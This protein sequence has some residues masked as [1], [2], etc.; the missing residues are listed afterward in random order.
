MTVETSITERSEG[1]A[2]IFCPSKRVPRLGARP[3]PL[4]VL[5]AAQAFVAARVAD[6]GASAVLRG[7]TGAAF[8]TDAGNAILDCRFGPIA[9]PAA[10]ATALSAIPG[11]FGH[12]LF[13]T[14]IDGLYI[15]DAAGNVALETRPDSR[16]CKPPARTATQEFSTHD[17]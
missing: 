14:E 1:R 11:V 3:V 17:R 8:V 15:A 12:G 2:A 9:D 10:L 5:P 4:E 6:L 13:V 7:G 16:N